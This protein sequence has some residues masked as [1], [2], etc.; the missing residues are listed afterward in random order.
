[1]SLIA[2]VRCGC[3]RSM[4]CGAIFIYLN[5]RAHRTHTGD[6]TAVI[7]VGIPYTGFSF[8]GFDAEL[9]HK[10]RGG[11]VFICDAS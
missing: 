9:F 10:S 6:V 2:W 8:F 7:V 1:M 5:V 11:F 4:L 3:S